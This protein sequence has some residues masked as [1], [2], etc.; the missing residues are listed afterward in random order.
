MASLLDMLDGTVPAKLSV[1]L[2]Q[3]PLVEPITLANLIEASFEGYAPTDFI[4]LDRASPTEGWGACRGYCS[5]TYNGSA[6]EILLTALYLTA[7]DNQKLV[8]LYAIPMANTVYEKIGLGT[9]TY[10][11]SIVTQ[12][13]VAPE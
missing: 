11:V 8:L 9:M 6:P 12:V 5:F 1:H 3:S 13:D 4:A 7:Y 2:S 10:F